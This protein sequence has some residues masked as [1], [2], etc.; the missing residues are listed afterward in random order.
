MAKVSTEFPIEP[1]SAHEGGRVDRLVQEL[2]GWSRAQVNGLFDHDCVY[3]NDV[4]THEPGQR[5]AAGDVLKLTYD[6]ARRYHPKPRS[7][8]HP[9]FEVIYEDADLIVVLKPQELLTVPTRRGEQN[10]LADRV[11]EYVRRVSGGRGAFVV[12]RLDRGVSGLLIFGK[13]REVMERIKDQFA[14]HKPQRRYIAAVVGELEVREGTFHS[15]LATDK[16]LNRFSTEDKHIGQDAI[17]HYK[18]LERLAFARGPLVSLVEVHLETGRRHQIRVHFAE[19]GHPVVGDPRYGTYFARHPSWPYRRLALH[20]QSL[21]ITHPTTG[22][23]MVFS[24]QLPAEMTALLA[25]AR[26]RNKE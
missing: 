11:Q 4:L 23:E 5:L 12:H 15:L 3:V 10:T 18:V 24:S 13:S 7:H 19:S 26:T 9:G 2:T 16:A 1:A 22:E 8:R 20:A 21:G 6:N 17:T 14:A 25:A